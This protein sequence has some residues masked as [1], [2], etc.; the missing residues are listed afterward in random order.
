M[1]NRKP[2]FNAR[3]TDPKLPGNSNNKPPPPHKEF[4]DYWNSVFKYNF[5]CVDE[6]KENG[7]GKGGKLVGAHVHK[8]GS[9]T[10]G[11]REESKLKCL[12]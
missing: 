6:C 1:D 12:F 4:V 10:N 11:K 5:C 9:C 3:G 2:F 8:K 7:T